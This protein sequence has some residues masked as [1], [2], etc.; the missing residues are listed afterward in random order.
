MGSA[1]TERLAAQGHS[2]L[3]LTRSPPQPG[4]QAVV[5]DPAAGVLAEHEL[6]GVDA[7]VHLAGE[8][9]LSRWTAARKTRIRDSRV[10]GTALL[11]RALAK[12]ARPP[13]VLVSMS[14]TG[15]YGDRCDETLD[16]N[17]AQGAGFLADVAR[18]WEEATAPARDRGI[19]VVTPRMGVVLTPLGGALA[20]ML[21]AFRLGLGG[22]VGSGRQ[23][24][25]W[26]SLDDAVSAIA[27]AMREPSLSGALNLVAP[28]PVTNRVFTRALGRALGRPTPFP[29]PA[30]ALRLAMGEMARE[31]LLAST[32]AYP[33]KLMEAQFAFAH[34]DIESALSQML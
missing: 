2:L 21:P 25:S 14:A 13:A 19:R 1:L 31:L 17:C 3:R 28:N 8:R 34:A 12:T 4:Q 10:L 29:V 6:E 22:R 9:V 24:V 5:W 27:F 16:E 33:R 18:Q 15:Y 30:I 23:Y 11:S 20:M 7:V 32:R 26:I